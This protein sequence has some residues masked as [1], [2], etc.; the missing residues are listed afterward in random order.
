M[1]S[2]FGHVV[3]DTAIGIVLG[4]LLFRYWRRHKH[5]VAVE[6]LQRAVP[7]QPLLDKYLW[8]MHLWPVTPASQARQVHI[9]WWE[10]QSNGDDVPTEV[11]VQCAFSPVAA[12]HLATMLERAAHGASHTDVE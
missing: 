10:M 2:L 12:D 8:R 3:L 1:D 6:F 4:L 5:K 9:G 7:L 11:L